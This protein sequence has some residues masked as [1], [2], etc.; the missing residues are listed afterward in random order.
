MFSDLY[1]CQYT[2]VLIPIS[3]EIKIECPTG[4]YVPRVGTSGWCPFKYCFDTIECWLCRHWFYIDTWRA[5]KFVMISRHFELCPQRGHITTESQRNLEENIPMFSINAV[6]WWPDTVR[7][8][9]HSDGSYTCYIRTGQVVK[10]N[11]LIP[12][13]PVPY[14]YIPSLFKLC[15]VHVPQNHQQ[16]WL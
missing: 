7:Y 3:H 13:R 15:Q 6:C 4:N 16:T 5:A 11:S 2:L 9:S 14:K 10:C 1:F 12:T 8:C